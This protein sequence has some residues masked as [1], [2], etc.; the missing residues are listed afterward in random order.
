MV[1]SSIRATM[2]RTNTL[3]CGSRHSWLSSFSPRKVET[4]DV[5]IL[6]VCL[7][8]LFWWFSSSNDELGLHSTSFQPYRGEFSDR[9]ENASRIKQGNSWDK[10]LATTR[11][12]I[13]TIVTFYP[14]LNVNIDYLLRPL[15][16][17]HSPECIL[18][19]DSITNEDALN[20]TEMQPINWRLFH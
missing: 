11:S 4:D 1:D 7:K 20:P 14:I 5:I 12:V 19:R 6:H 16:C 3:L 9:R 18:C 10:Q 8:S 17:S 2:Q 15:W 13:K